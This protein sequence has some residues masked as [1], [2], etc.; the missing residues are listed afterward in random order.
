MDCGD[1]T[2]VWL[3]GYDPTPCKA[4]FAAF[5]SFVLAAG[6]PPVRAFEFTQCG[7]CAE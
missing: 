6:A 1:Y 7:E 4:Q 5:R 2:G 3:S